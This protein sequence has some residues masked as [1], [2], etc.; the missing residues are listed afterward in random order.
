MFRKNPKRFLVAQQ[1]HRISELEKK[2]RII[3]SFSFVESRKGEAYNYVHGLMTKEE[4]IRTARE[5]NEN[6]HRFMNCGVGG[7]TYVYLVVEV[8]AEFWVDHFYKAE[9]HESLL[10]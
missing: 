7:K 4:A 5:L 9:V 1:L 8:Q 10:S 6:H 2:D 3:Y